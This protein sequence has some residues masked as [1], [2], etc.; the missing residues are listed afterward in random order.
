VTCHKNDLLITEK[1]YKQGNEE[2][3]I[4]GK[5]HAWLRK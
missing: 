3:C 2:K 1:K 4:K 5:M